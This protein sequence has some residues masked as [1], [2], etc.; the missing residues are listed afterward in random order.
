MTGGSPDNTVITISGSG[1]YR[2][3]GLTNDAGTLLFTKEG[4]SDYY[5]MGT[6]GVRNL[7]SN[8]YKNATGQSSSSEQSGQ[9]LATGFGSSGNGNGSGTGYGDNARFISDSNGNTIDLN[10]LESLK[11]VSPQSV[12]LMLRRG[13]P[14]YNPYGKPNTYV[15]SGNGHAIVFGPEGKA[16]YDVSEERIKNTF[17][18]VSPETGKEYFNPEGVKIFNRKNST[19]VV[20]ESVLKILGVTK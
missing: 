14:V 6:G 20:P 13:H 7:T 10:Y 8:G 15:N 9:F 18:N 3:T 17:Y 11:E 2:S 19:S 16:L 1:T 12:G 4:S 5:S